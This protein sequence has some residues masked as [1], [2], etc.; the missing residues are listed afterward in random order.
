M[1]SNRHL[2]I[3]GIAMALLAF[4][5][6]AFGHQLI[7]RPMQAEL[8]MGEGLKFEAIVY[9]EQHQPIANVNVDWRVEPVGLGRIS[10]DGFFIAGREPGRGEV[11]ATAVIGREQLVG[12]AQVQVGRPQEPEIRIIVKP[13]EAVVPPLGSEQFSAV[14]VGPDGV[15]L[16]TRGIR[17]Q[18]QPP[19][20]GVIRAN[21]VFQAGP[22]MAE[23]VVIALVEINQKVY[24]GEAKVIVS[25]PA[26][27]AIQG[28]VT[29][30]TGDALAQVYVSA[31]RLGIPSFTQRAKTDEAGN[32]HLGGLIPGIY[33]VRAE[34]RGYIGEY[35]DD[36]VN[37]TEADPLR[38]SEKDTLKG[39]NFS[40]STGGSITGHIYAD[41]KNTPLEGAHVRAHL[42]NNPT[43]MVHALSAAD[44][45]YA[46][47]GLI[48][49]S[50][51]VYAQKEGYVGKFYQTD[52]VDN[53]R[54]TPVEVVAP[55]ETSNIDIILSTVSALAGTLTNESDGLPI[56][57]AVV[58]A[59]EAI[60][61]QKREAARSYRAV[62]DE[63]GK[64]TMALRTGSYFVQAMAAGFVSEWYDNVQDP[65]KATAV[66]I[67]AGQHT[68]VN[69]SLMP[70]GCI[71]GKVVDAVSLQPIAGA[72]VRAYGELRN[73]KRFVETLT[74][75]DGS[76][77]LP[78]LPP[79]KYYVEAQ[80]RGYL[81]EFWEEA[82][83][84]RNATVVVV[85]N[86]ATVENID[87]T[88]I[89]GGSICGIV[90][91][92]ANGLPIADAVV[93]VVSEDGT[94]K[95]SAK[96]GVDGRYVVDGL[97]SGNYYVTATALNYYPQ[98]YADA[99]TRREATAVA[100][101]APAVTEGID[102][103][104]TQIEPRPRS[105]SGTVVD[106]ST[107]LPIQ[108]A[109]VTAM[110]VRTFG[111]VGRAIS[112]AE[113]RYII[114]GLEPGM[115]VL[116]CHAPGY[117]GEY[118]PDARSWKDAKPIEVRRGEEVT[119]IDF[120][121]APQK[122]GPYTVNGR[123]VA[124]D[125]S[126]VAD[127][128]VSLQ[129]EEE[130]TAAVVTDA[131]GSFLI[132]EVPADAYGLG[133]SAAGYEDAVLST[134]SLKVGNG[135]NIYSVD[136]TLP[137]TTTH[138][139][140]SE[141]KPLE[142]SLM[143]N[144]PNPFNPVTEIQFSLAATAQVKLKVYNLLGEVVAT[145]CDRMMPAGLHTTVWDGTDA[146]GNYL[147]SGVYFYRIE[148]VYGSER[149]TQMRRMLLMK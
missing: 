18:V 7:V 107:G 114:V 36:A 123:I 65:Q 21:G 13:E 119:D 105:I 95:R 128:L 115:Y 2:L 47:T 37:I 85:E 142:F 23:G 3:L 41:D 84:L 81:P 56:R 131:D 46:L 14:A 4:A 74:R 133:V 11:I 122:R 68:I 140:A 39:I 6:V 50:Y 143:Q 57:G 72:M 117:I 42:M 102:F 135:M 139:D 87:F 34:K 63:N 20:L 44:G 10:E 1:K 61:T 27:S 15:V 149:F 80:A 93:T 30:E 43:V 91:D 69:M 71:S 141:M 97:H 146:N 144:Y 49:G 31:I 73:S 98:W 96:S 138:V 35:Y 106:D 100:V 86:G 5:A 108:H 82:D 22:V 112:D 19:T 60:S 94:M 25:P 59:Q 32:Y 145:L 64:Y 83:S 113:G 78:A 75:E 103:H 16:V 29:D 45:S 40:L 124:K 134:N 116:L 52:V 136:L 101:E 118:Y 109:V 66:Q 148:A 55:N 79:G 110:P 24:R 132:A 130:A 67:V 120:G 89:H 51:I 92:I 99:A 54:P 26:N 125:G 33:L 76:Y 137:S 53:Q 90:S 88:L 28:I 127:A 77:K 129:T 126:A 8:A 147:S 12:R 38:L 70:L 48:S 9:N 62:T 17:W 111:R 104:L 121:L 58:I